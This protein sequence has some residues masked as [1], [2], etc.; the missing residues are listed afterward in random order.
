MVESRSG[1]PEKSFTLGAIAE[2][3]GATLKGDPTTGISGIGAL[4]DA[5]PG[6]L[7]F[8]TSPR[9]S[10][11]LSECRASALIAPPSLKD[12][13]FPLLISHQPYLALAKAAQLFAVPPFL[14]SGIHD[15]VVMG[16]NVE[17]AQGVSVGALCQIGSNCRIGKGSKLYGGVYLGGEVELGEGCVLYPGVTVMDRCRIGN[18]VIIHSGTV[19]GSDGFGYAQDDKGHHIKIPQTGI[20]QV[21][22]D[23]E[24]GSNCSIDRATFSRTWIKRGA[25]IDNLV[26]I[27]HNVV[28]GEHSILVAQVGISGSVRLGKHVILAGQVGVAGHLEIGDR[29]R[30][31]AKSGVGHSIKAGEDMA[32]IPVLPQKEWLRNIKNLQRMSTFKDE[33]RQLKARVEQIEKGSR[34]KKV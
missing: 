30:I 21:D 13:P 7:S 8:I 11:L 31:G 10:G 4:E 34:E 9:Y 22:D 19:I 27:G 32:G 2:L 29:V 24:I 12:L 16:D 14:S 26:Q 6:E 20:V 3:V 23:V 1:N 5:T 33:L 15:S 18:R 25:K 17:L 28:V